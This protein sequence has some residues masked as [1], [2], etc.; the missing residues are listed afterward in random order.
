MRP[1]EDS[2]Y[3]VED[4]RYRA[5]ILSRELDWILKSSIV[6]PAFSAE[7]SHRGCL[8]RPDQV[9]EGTAGF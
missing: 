4:S 7:T 2:R 5:L 8:P 6:L 9:S 3:R 1:F